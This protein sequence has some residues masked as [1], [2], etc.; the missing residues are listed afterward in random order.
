MGWIL[1]PRSWNSEG[2]KRN[3]IHGFHL[4]GTL[5]PEPFMSV[6]VETVGIIGDSNSWFRFLESDPGDRHLLDQDGAS[7][8]A[9]AINR[10]STNRYDLA[11]H[12]F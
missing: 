6:E 9:A 7:G 4:V 2:F 5:F 1:H 8:L 11:E 3:G 10:V 12:V